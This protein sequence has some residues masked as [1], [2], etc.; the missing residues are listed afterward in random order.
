ME[1]KERIAEISVLKVMQIILRY[2]QVGRLCQSTSRGNI[3]FLLRGTGVMRR[4]YHDQ[5]AVQE[6]RE[7]HGDP[8]KNFSQLLESKVTNKG[9]NHCRRTD[10]SAARD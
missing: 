10:W 3:L 7:A 4:V 9:Y 6:A 1:K 8:G 2:G 5:E